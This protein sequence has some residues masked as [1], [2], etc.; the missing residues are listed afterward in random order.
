MSSS[1]NA[2]PNGTEERIKT[3]V[4]SAC[5]APLQSHHSATGREVSGLMLPFPILGL[6]SE[7]AMSSWAAEVTE[8]LPSVI[9]AAA[10]G[11]GAGTGVGAGAGSGARLWRRRSRRRLPS[12][13]RHHCA[14]PCCFTAQPFHC[15]AFPCSHQDRA[16]EQFVKQYHSLN[17]P[18]YPHSIVIWLF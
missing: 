10:V 6:E 18:A 8:R 7:T 16:N 5:T 17:V 11:V 15:I 3:L 9:T 2:I 14:F 12:A 13:I 4:H 1:S